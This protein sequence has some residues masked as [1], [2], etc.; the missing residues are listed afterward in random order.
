[1][2]DPTLADLLKPEGYMTA[3]IGKNH[4]CRKSKSKRCGTRSIPPLRSWLDYK[5]DG[6]GVATMAFNNVSGIGRGGTGVL[7]VDGKEV[8]RNS[9]E[10]SIPLIL[11][12]DENFDIG[13][14]TGTPVSDDY[15]VPFRFTGKLDKLTLTIDRPK[16]SPEDIEKLTETGRN[17]R[18]SE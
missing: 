14:D 6:L 17:N 1:M 3:Q 7:K 11:Q 15:Q 4:L 9:M 13:A 18:A 16:L 12:W 8:A 5:Y 10:R 2:E